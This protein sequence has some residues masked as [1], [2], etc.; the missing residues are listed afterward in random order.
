MDKNQDLR[1][2]INIPDPQHWFIDN[3]KIKC[4]GSAEPFPT[5]QAVSDRKGSAP[6]PFPNPVGRRQ[7]KTI[8]TDTKRNPVQLYTDGTF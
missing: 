1:S 7:I 3:K 5:F 2:V 8:E 6:G 4:G